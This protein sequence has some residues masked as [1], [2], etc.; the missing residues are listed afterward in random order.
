MA[1]ALSIDAS[2]LIDL[3]RERLGA[4]EGAAYRFLRREPAAELCLAT[5]ALGELTEGFGGPA[6]PALG[7]IRRCHRL[8]PVDED[9]A[10]AYARVAR[11]LRAGGHL[12]GTNDLW[13]AATS[14]RHGLP[15]VTSDV[16]RFRRVGG[17]EVLGYR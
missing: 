10:L 14:L 13:V 2:F 12:L 4:Q 1:R 6:H 17:L 15:L 11:E 8:L 5:T 9:V 3:E 7:A 16:E